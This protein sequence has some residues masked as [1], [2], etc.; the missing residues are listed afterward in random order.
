MSQ[1]DH[2]IKKLNGGVV[3]PPGVEFLSAVKRLMELERGKFQM[4]FSVFNQKFKVRLL[5]HSD[6]SHT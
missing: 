1:F 3:F 2:H 4:I 5:G 6:N